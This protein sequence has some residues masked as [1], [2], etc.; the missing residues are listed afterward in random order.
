MKKLIQS[1]PLI[2]SRTRTTVFANVSA[3]THKGSVTRTL[4]ATVSERYTLVKIGSATNT[5]EP[6]GVSDRPLGIAT[7][8][9]A[10]G[11]A[12]NVNLPGTTGQTQLLVAAAA[13]DAGDLV[14]VATGGRIQ[15][16][17]NTAGQ[18]YKIGTALSSA[19]AAGELVEVA[20]HSPQLQINVAAFEGNATNDLAK[21]AAALVQNPDKIRLL[22][23]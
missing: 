19:A 21:L 17:P 16:L 5:V 18:F 1:I 6:C 10:S 7:D 20:T 8:T 12:I 22:G 23:A 3:G 9:G 14:Y 15:R 4:S 13:I 2:A 11:E